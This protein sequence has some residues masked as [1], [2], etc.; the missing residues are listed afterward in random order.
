MFEYLR[1]LQ[2][3]IQRKRSGNGSRRCQHYP[4]PKKWSFRPTIEAL[5]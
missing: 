4:G 1:F 2:Q 3:V 5:E